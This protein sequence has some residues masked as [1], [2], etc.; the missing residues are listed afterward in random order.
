[1][2]L[3]QKLE[4]LSSLETIS[5]IDGG[6]NATH[7]NLKAKELLDKH[8]DKVMKEKQETIK[9][10][11]GKEYKNY[12]TY[13]N[14]YACRFYMFNINNENEEVIID[15]KNNTFKKIEE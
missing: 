6:E 5:F 9:K 14:C 4:Y 12:D 1:M 2:K 8:F 10:I 3:W 13:S 7:Y 15:L 11:L